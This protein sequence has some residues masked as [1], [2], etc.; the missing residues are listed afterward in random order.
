MR[1]S[2]RKFAETT[3]H[4]TRPQRVVLVT[5]IAINVAVFV[6]QLAID[7]L[8][9]GFIR[10]YLA[11]SYTGVNDAYSWQFLSAIFLQTGPWHFVGNVFILYVLGRDLETIIGPR[12]F[13]YLYLS[14]AVGGELG[15]LFLMPRDSV[16]Y[17]STGGVAAIICAYAIVLPEMELTS[18]RWLLFRPK[19]K[20]VAAGAIV[21]ALILLCIDRSPR[22]A[23]SALIGGCLAGWLYASLLGF[24]GT[25]TWQRMLRRRRERAQRFEQMS[26][27]ELITQEIDPLLEKISRRGLRGLTRRE[28]RALLRAREKIV[29]TACE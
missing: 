1:L 13:L 7:T 10:D 28:H 9:P 23:H 26:V 12:H 2:G 18:T 15:H 4:W 6:A 24:G 17:A 29:R 19:A 8:S 27:A 25:S 14:G 20:H 11:I 22:V 21:L 3:G 5:L 16:L